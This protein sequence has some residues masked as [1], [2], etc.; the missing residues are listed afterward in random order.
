MPRQ[1]TPQQKEDALRQLAVNKGNVA[2]T[3]IQT[4]V[5]ERTIQRWQQRLRL[6]NAGAKPLPA[7]LSAPPPPKENTPPPSPPPKNDPPQPE[8]DDDQSLREQTCNELRSLRNQLMRHIFNIT[9]DL[10]Q[11]DDL[12]NHR[13]VAI[14]RLLDRVMKLDAQLNELHP[15]ETILRVVYTYPD[16]SVHSIPSYKNDEWQAQRKRALLDST[17]DRLDDED[18]T[19]SPPLA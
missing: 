14:T 16:G 12:F 4:G 7:P 10:S 2:L 11:D 6:E 8:T 5:S 9:A 17:Q 18:I 13:T 1:Y 19:K 15:Q 3:S